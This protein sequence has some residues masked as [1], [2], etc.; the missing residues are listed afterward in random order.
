MSDNCSV[1]DAGGQAILESLRQLSLSLGTT[2]DV[3]HESAAFMQWLAQVIRPKIAALFLMDDKREHLELV[4]A[5]GFKAE[6]RRLPVGLDPWQ[7]LRRHGA[8]ILPAE[9]SCCHALPLTVEGELFGLL[10][11][12]IR[13]RG[14][15]VDPG[16]HLAESAVSFFALHLRNIYRHRYVEQLVEQRTA[17]MRASEER[18]RTLFEESPVALLELDLSSVKKKLNRLRAQGLEDMNSYVQRH[19][20]FTSEILGEICLLKVNKAALQLFGCNSKGELFSFVGKECMDNL[21]DIWPGV[22]DLFY[23]GKRKFEQQISLRDCHGNLLHIVV[24]MVVL[25]AY[26]ESWKRVLVSLLDVTKEVLARRELEQSH[27]KLQRVLEGSVRSLAALVE[28]RDP[29]TAGH[30]QRVAELACAIA[31]ELN[32]PEERIQGLRMA[33]LLHDIGKVVVPA[34]ILTKP[35]RLSDLEFA[36]LKEHPQVGYEVLAGI[37]FP[38]PVAE[39]VRQYHERLDGSGYPRG[40]K[41]EEILLEAQI[42]AVADVV[43]AMIS[44]RPYRPAHTI[45]EAVEEIKTHQETLYNPDVVKICVD[46]LSSKKFVFKT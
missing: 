33:A 36:M 12:V 35:A 19:P 40:L 17:E 16:V 11:L 28:R 31:K 46:L 32:L 43:E 25:P 18:Y 44:H 6:H 27:T 4:Q 41:G 14:A 24:Q 26:A 7:W 8:G 42:L 9:N 29:Y 38:W 20:Q 30:Q 10:V 39:I 22:L 3:N 37:D 13:E 23:R 45:R 15:K 34:E 21:K 2:L 5:F 1:F